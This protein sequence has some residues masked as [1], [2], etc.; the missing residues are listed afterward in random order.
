M[1]IKFT[2]EEIKR[3]LINEARAMVDGYHVGES[4]LTIKS[5]YISD[6]TVDVELKEPA[7]TDYDDT[8]TDKETLT[9]DESRETELEIYD[10]LDM[11]SPLGFNHETK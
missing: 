10:P 7:F 9:V 4:E 1:N 2:E 5:A 8:A 3:I 11:K 6:V